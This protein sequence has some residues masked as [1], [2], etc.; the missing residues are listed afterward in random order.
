MAEDIP[1]PTTKRTVVDQRHLHGRRLWPSVH[2]HCRLSEALTEAGLSP[3][4]FRSVQ[5]LHGQPDFISIRF[6]KPEHAKK[7]IDLALYAVAV[8]GAPQIMV[9]F[10]R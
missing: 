8:D 1:T 2:T 3:S 10:C 4:M 5:F 6:I 9:F 7:F